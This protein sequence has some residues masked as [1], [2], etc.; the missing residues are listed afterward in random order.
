MK[1]FMSLVMLGWTY[2]ILSGLYKAT[3]ELGPNPTS[4]E[5]TGLGLAVM[6]GLVI[7]AIVMVPLAML[8]RMGGGKKKPATPYAPTKTCPACAETVL[9]AANVCKHCGAALNPL[10]GRILELPARRVG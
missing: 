4:A 6:F 8:A 7:W 5:H 2:L 9:Q 1:V 3:T 10:Q